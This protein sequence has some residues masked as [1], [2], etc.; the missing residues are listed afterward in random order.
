MKG[1]GSRTAG[2][3]SLIEFKGETHVVNWANFRN[4]LDGSGLRIAECK[5]QPR[6]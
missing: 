3:G 2:S 4:I 6:T 5:E 1:E